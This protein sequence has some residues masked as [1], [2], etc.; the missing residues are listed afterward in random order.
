MSSHAPQLDTTSILQMDL[1]MNVQVLKIRGLNS[2]RNIWNFKSSI[3]DC[4]HNK[5]AYFLVSFF[6][7]RRLFFR[8]D[9]L[10]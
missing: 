8:G 6:G 7:H 4:S 2:I 10:N 3:F 9:E 1:F 5:N